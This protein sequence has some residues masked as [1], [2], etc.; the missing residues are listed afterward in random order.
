MTAINQIECQLHKIPARSPDL[1]PI[2][3]FFH[4]LKKSLENEAIEQQITKETFSDF[5]QRVLRCI[6]TLDTSI[7]D[8]TI[9]SMPKRVNAILLSKGRRI[10]Y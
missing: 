7:L 10:K 2:E 9:E 3:N 8:R 4:I 5:T 1:N 6:D